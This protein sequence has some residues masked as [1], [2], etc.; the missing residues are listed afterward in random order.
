MIPLL[1]LL[2]LLVP[3]E[4]LAFERAL[5]PGS[6]LAGLDRSSAALIGER[7]FKNEAA[8]RREWLV[9]WLDGEDH[10]S[11]GIGHFI[12]YPAGRTGPYRESFPE[13]L[14]F[15]E[16]Q[17]VA[18]PGWLSSRT[19]A[20][21][22]D[23][24]AFLAARGEPMLEQLRSWLIVTMPHQTA[25]MTDRL[26]RAVPVMLQSAAPERRETIRRRIERLLFAPDGRVRPGG[27]YALID[28]VN[29]KG[30]GTDPAERHQGIGWGLLQVL[31][32]MT[33]G[34]SDPRVAFADAAERVLRRRVALAP[35]GRPEDRWLAGWLIRVR[36][37]G[38]FDVPAATSVD[39]AAQ[40]S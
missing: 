18:M 11:L 17:G 2:L 29:F 39:Q 38:T 40:G 8:G 27:A 7:I 16:R 36:T 3:L 20:P 21:W 15:V 33:P 14:A 13:F 37:Y 31:D 10:L 25:F 23:R 5:A 22:P 4:V 1:R 32:E 30:D 9:H 24:T 28:Y 19:P 26:A 34:A 6:L 12:W 35:A